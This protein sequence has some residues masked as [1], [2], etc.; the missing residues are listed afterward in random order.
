MAA[1][2]K[3]AAWLEWIASLMGGASRQRYAAAFPP[4]QYWCLLDEL[5]LHLIPP[6]SLPS[7][8]LDRGRDFV[9]NPLARVLPQGQIP[10]EVAARPTLLERFTLQGTIAWVQR[11]ET[12]S[13]LPFWLSPR[14][15][16]TLAAVTLEGSL[17]SKLSPEELCILIAAGLLRTD[18]QAE[19]ERAQEREVITR[20]AEMFQERDY[21]PIRNLIHPFHVAS[22]RR[23][24]RNIIRRGMI[25]LGD[26]QCSRRYGV[27][28]ESVARFF[29]HH[30]AQT[31][32]AVVGEPVKPSYV[33]SACY[34]SGAELNKHID[35]EQ[36][37][38]SVTLC[39]DFSPEPEKETPWPIRLDTP[40]GPVSVYQALGDG[41]VYR[42][43]RVPHYRDVLAEGRTSTSIFFHYV[44]ESYTGSL[45]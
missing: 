45:D 42:G 6:G 27:H 19:G 17:S 21:A 3:D 4:D 23:Y 5:P 25:D 28:N 41:L 1:P 30:L 15:E 12:D 43:T 44:P 18:E 8:P 22:L 24:F 26:E 33:Y 31:V 16:E 38:Y 7:A 32:S 2:V 36:C 39:L 14:L 10:A 35:R 13:L 34:L 20:S 9:L 11:S 29:H 37:E 40:Q